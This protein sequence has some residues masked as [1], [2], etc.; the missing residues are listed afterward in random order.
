MLLLIEQCLQLIALSRVELLQMRE[1][2]GCVVLCALG[3]CEGLLEFGET[4]ID[5]VKLLRL[6]LIG[7]LDLLQLAVGSR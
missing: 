3:L 5:G 2:A 6:L 4:M 7:E 1:P